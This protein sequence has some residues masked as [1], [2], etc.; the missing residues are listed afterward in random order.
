MLTA[1]RAL[2][3]AADGAAPPGL[4]PGRPRRRHSQVPAC[5]HRHALFMQPPH[6]AGDTGPSPRRLCAG[7]WGRAASQSGD[8]RGPGAQ[9]RAPTG[10]QRRGPQSPRGCACEPPPRFRGPSPAGRSAAGPRAGSLRRRR[11]RRRCHR[12][13]PRPP[14]LPPAWSRPQ[15]PSAY[16]TSPRL[17]G[18][19]NAGLR[20]SPRSNSA[21]LA[22]GAVRLPSMV[23]SGITCVLMIAE[24]ANGAPGVA[25]GLQVGRV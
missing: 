9:M 14:C 20:L 24:E 16:T 15:G 6:V 25:A 22:A 10:S 21:R 5:G 4:M 19:R 18:P 2:E 13:A 12:A 3:H 11:R 23:C 1:A 7:F 17:L 8:A